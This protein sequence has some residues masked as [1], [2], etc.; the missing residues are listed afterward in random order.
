MRKRLKN[1][2]L[3]DSGMQLARDFLFFYS[4][5][6]LVTK[7]T[8]EA[9]AFNEPLPLPPQRRLSAHWI[10]K[11]ERSFLM[12]LSKKHMYKWNSF[13]GVNDANENGRSVLD[14][15]TFL[16]RRV[17]LPNETGEKVPF[18]LHVSNEHKNDVVL[19]QIHR[20]RNSKNF[21]A[22]STALKCSLKQY[23]RIMKIVLTYC[24]KLNI[25]AKTSTL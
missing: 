22:F 8:S 25:K 17:L 16:S 20:L 4:M 9:Q 19:F 24:C 10:L 7:K 1:S 15:R 12:D 2:F 6:L 5:V 14:S 21:I 23:A 3:N 13:W 18:G 11:S